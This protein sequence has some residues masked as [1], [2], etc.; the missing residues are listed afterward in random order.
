MAVDEQAASTP[1]VREG[2]PEGVAWPSG[3]HDQQTRGVVER[4][5]ALCG[6]GNETEPLGWVVN[7]AVPSL[8]VLRMSGCQWY[9]PVVEAGVAGGIAAV[10]ANWIIMV[11][12]SDILVSACTA[13]SYPAP[14][15]PK[16]HCPALLHYVMEQQSWPLCILCHW[17][18]SITL[19]A[20]GFGAT[21]T[22]AL[23]SPAQLCPDPTASLA[24]HPL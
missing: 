5:C 3:G 8:H 15:S 7:L 4:E 18:E 14:L 1:T 13:L 21:G 23:L 19:T 16:Q 12:N 2:G 24:R 11:H 6:N 10:G 9:C 22:T 20:Q 17:S